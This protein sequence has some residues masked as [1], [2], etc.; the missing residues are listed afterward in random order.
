MPYGLLVVGGQH[1]LEPEGGSR[2]F[3]WMEILLGET[4]VFLIEDCLFV[5]SKS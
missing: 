3:H 5:V 2:A 4:S 1:T